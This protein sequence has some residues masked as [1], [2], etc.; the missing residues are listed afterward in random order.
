MKTHITN[1]TEAIGNTPLLRLDRITAHLELAGAIF[2]KLEHLNPSFSKKDRIA[3]GMIEYAEQSGL[4]KP[5]QPILEMTSGN[6]GTG[7]ALVCAAKGYHFICVMSR[8][9]SVERIKMI[10]GFGGEVVL[11]NQA[12]GAIPG[13]VSGED[14]KL[15][16]IETERLLKETGA[17]YLNQFNNLDNA[18]SQEAAAREIWEQSQG[19]IEVFAD[20]IGTGGTFGGY[21]RALKHKNPAIRC[22]AVEP[23]G[24]AHYLGELI[25]GANH[26]IQGGGYAK[27]MPNA[28]RASM[29]GIVAVTDAEAVE[30]TRLLAKK[31]GIFAGFSSGANLMAAV[32]LLQTEEKG[33]SIAIVIND[34][35]LK[36]MSTSLW[37]S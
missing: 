1:I 33:K 26:G 6:T 36:Y 18:L 30:M 23:H 29:D 25:E 21:A 34:C 11:V 28:D 31:E 24:C 4:L 13:K 10:E 2:A 3:L 19:Q 12:P 15:V 9:N 37:D 17:F 8:G 22:Y 16:E 20:F 14:L 35:G 5:G 7:V 27:A 32:K